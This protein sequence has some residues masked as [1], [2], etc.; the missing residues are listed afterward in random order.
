MI[1]HCNHDIWRIQFHSGRG[2]CSR[3]GLAVKEAAVENLLMFPINAFMASCIARAAT[4]QRTLENLAATDWNGTV[5]VEFDDETILAPLERHEE[6]VR[7]ILRRAAWNGPEMFL[8]LED[9]LDF[10]LHFVYNLTAWPPLLRFSP[11]DHF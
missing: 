11:G 9:D 3:S 1:S 4:R 10:N 8:F 2:L 6:L 7:R 5:T